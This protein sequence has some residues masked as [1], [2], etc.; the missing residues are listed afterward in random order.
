MLRK[1]PFLPG[2]DTKSQIELICEYFGTPNVDDIKQI[3]EESKKLIRNLPKRTGRAFNQIFSFASPDALDLLKKLLMF[4]PAKRITVEEA[5]K[6]PYLKNLHLEEDEPT[7]DLVDPLDFEFE[8]HNL[9]M[10]QLKG[11]ILFM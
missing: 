5:L 8:A 7:R 1:R 2:A 11:T 10:Q 4:D 3:P 6:H 9:T